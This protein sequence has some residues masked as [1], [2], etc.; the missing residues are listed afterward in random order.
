MSPP[1]PARMMPTTNAAAMDV[2]GLRLTMLS[3]SAVRLLPP[4]AAAAAM[5]APW[6]ARPEDTSRADRI[7]SLPAFDRKVASVSLRPLRSRTSASR[8]DPAK[9]TASLAALPIASL[10]R[11]SNSTTDALDL[12]LS[13]PTLLFSMFHL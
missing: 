4:S 8:S 3:S 6:S 2:S 9:S 1:P 5:L 13:A 11:V 10:V 7:A 12:A